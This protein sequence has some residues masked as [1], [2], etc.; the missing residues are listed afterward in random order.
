MVR[1]DVLLLFIA[2]GKLIG[3][4]AAGIARNC[5]CVYVHLSPQCDLVAPY[6]SHLPALKRICLRH[7]HTCL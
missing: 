5:V 2:G 3:A 6:Y 7:S 1:W 4:S